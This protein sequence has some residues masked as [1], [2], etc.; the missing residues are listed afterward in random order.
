MRL[1]HILIWIF[2]NFVILAKLF[3]SVL[4]N[5]LFLIGRNFVTNLKFWRSFIMTV[6]SW[7]SKLVEIWCFLVKSLKQFLFE[8]EKNPEHMI[9][10]P[11]N[12]W[13]LLTY[14]NPD[15]LNEKFKGIAPPA[16]FQTTKCFWGCCSSSHRYQTAIAPANGLVWQQFRNEI[17]NQFEL[18]YLLLLL[19]RTCSCPVLHRSFPRINPLLH[20]F[21][22][23]NVESSSNLTS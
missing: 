22:D 4:V 18:M 10:K 16:V 19:T 6:I 8:S 7:I 11:Y 13:T 12:F 14:N 9:G 21:Y 3:Q 1:L 23:S 20:G 2:W 17:S 15:P 5:W